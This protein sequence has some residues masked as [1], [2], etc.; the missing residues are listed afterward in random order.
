MRSVVV[1]VVLGAVTSV[2]VAWGCGLLSGVLPVIRT[3]VISSEV[4]ADAC[5]LLMFKTSDRVGSRQVECVGTVSE[6]VGPKSP[7]FR[8]RAPAEFSPWVPL[9][10]H[11]PVRRPGYFIH[12][13]Y[14]SGWPFRCVIGSNSKTSGYTG[15]SGIHIV[16]ASKTYWICSHPYWPGLA[17]NTAIYA[18]VWWIG[19]FGF[20]A[21]RRSIRVRRGCC[22]MCAY[23][24]RHKIAEGC[25]ECGWNR[26]AVAAASSA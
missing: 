18:S 5:K 20:A 12:K 3:N 8:A 22:P 10:E 14:A 15:S 17:A 13:L 1:V 19:L 4:P 25:P 11:I 7:N 16:G 2:G 23:D 9:I 21:I 26:V 24:L 6:L